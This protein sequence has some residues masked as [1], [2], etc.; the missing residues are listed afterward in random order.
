MLMNFQKITY[1]QKWLQIMSAISI[2]SLG[3]FLTLHWPSEAA[4]ELFKAYLS[5]NSSTIE[6][7]DTIDIQ[8]KLKSDKE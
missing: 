8:V 6:Q 1:K 7:S 5:P 2:S 4:D 3:L